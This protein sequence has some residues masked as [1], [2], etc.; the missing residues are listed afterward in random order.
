MKIYKA[1]IDPTYCT[2]MCTSAYVFYYA[3]SPEEALSKVLTEY[4]DMR[5]YR[6]K[7]PK[8][9]DY[10]PEEVTDGMIIWID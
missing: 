3:S 4:P 10:L 2:E 5:K 9:S 7:Y 8:T 6:K 1:F